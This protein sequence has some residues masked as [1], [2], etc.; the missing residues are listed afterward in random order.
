MT[1][2]QTY[3]LL[4]AAF[5]RYTDKHTATAK[6]AKKA[7]IREGLYTT[8]GRLKVAYGGGSKAD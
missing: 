5:E 4:E 2:V 3:K 6:D 7:M 1:E 8:K